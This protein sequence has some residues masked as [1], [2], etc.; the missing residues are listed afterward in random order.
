DSQAGSDTKLTVED[1]FKPEFKVH[2]PEAKWINGEFCTLVFTACWSHSC[3][4]MDHLL[5]LF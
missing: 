4:E 2:D 3:N 5:A 1:L